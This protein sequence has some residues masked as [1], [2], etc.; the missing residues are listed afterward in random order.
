MSGVLAKALY[1]GSTIA[2]DEFDARIHPLICQ[3][4]VDIFNSPESNPMGAQLIISTHD[5]NL[6]SSKTFRRDQICFVKQNA[7]KHSIVY[8]L[9]DV[10]LPNGQPPRTDSNYEKNYLQ[11]LYDSI[12][13]KDLQ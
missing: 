2:I 12:P 4:I 1:T 11:Q 10:V 8:S 9:L 13:S 6:M 7:I 5:T 3:K